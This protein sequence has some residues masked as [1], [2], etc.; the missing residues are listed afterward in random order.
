MSA[1]KE[2]VE[3]GVAEIRTRVEELERWR[4]RMEV[5]VPAAHAGVVRRRRVRE[6]ARRSRLKG[7]RPGK[8]PDALVERQFEAD[9]DRDVLEDLVREGF[10]SGVREAALDPIGA[11]RF[12]NVHWTAGGDLEFAAEFDVRPRIELGRATGFRVEERIRTVTDADVERVLERLRR[13]RSDWVAVDRPAAPGDRVRFDSVPEDEE[14]R[15]METERIENHVVELGS[16]TILD[17]F[18]TGL[19]GRRPGEE[20]TFDVRFPDDHRNEFLRGRT[21]TFR[22]RVGEVLERSLPPLDDDFARSAGAFES[23]A[24]LRERLRENLQAE[25]RE[26]ARREVNEQLIDAVIE[27]NRI[28]L[29]ETMVDQYLANLLADR[30]GGE[31]DDE[32]LA[33]IRQV[34]RPGA[35]RALRRHY[36]LNH[37]ADRENLTATDEDVDGAIAERID[38]GKTTVAETRRRL[39]RS[40]EIE[41]LRLHLTMERVFEWLRKGSEITPVEVADGGNE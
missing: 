7:F 28:D 9:I 2:R 18:E 6:Y 40:G 17:D 31:M 5:H 22:V 19:Q 27:A 1:Q 8:A 16:G 10:E 37:L 11:P 33:E 12:R 21:R 24:A 14:G 25:A 23:L 29:P 20:T 15:P 35:E 39:A 3:V 32:R 4:R 38:P 13:E 34:L 26:Q 30:T 36:I 41:D